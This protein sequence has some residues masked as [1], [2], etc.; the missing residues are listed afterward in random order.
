MIEYMRRH[1][2]VTVLSFL[3]AVGCLYVV[4]VTLL[5]RVSFASAFYWFDSR[6]DAYAIPAWYYIPEHLFLWLP[7]ILMGAT[8][9]I[10]MYYKSRRVSE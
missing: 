8:P 10:L 5:Y 4:G 6:G 1:W 9:L 2:V 7:V 3:W